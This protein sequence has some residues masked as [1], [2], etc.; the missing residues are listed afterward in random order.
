MLKP[1]ALLRPRI[2]TAAAAAAAA[3]AATTTMSASSSGGGGGG[4]GG[5]GNPWG[6]P[7]LLHIDWKRIADLPMGVEDNSGG[8]LDADTLVTGF[9]LGCPTPQPGNATGCFLAAPN[10]S[11]PHDIKCWSRPG[12]LLHPGTYHG[13]PHH[14]AWFSR[15]YAINVSAA[16]NT[17]QW[18][19][20]PLPPLSPRQ[21]TCGA[22][23]PKTNSLYIAGGWSGWTKPY[24][25]AHADAARLQRTRKG[26]WQWTTLPDLPNP[27]VFGGMTISADGHVFVFGVD[28]YTIPKKPPIPACG[29]APAALFELDP[30]KLDAG[31]ISHHFPGASGGSAFATAGNQ[32]FLMPGDPGDGKRAGVWRFDLATTSWHELPGSAVA[33]INGFANANNAIFH[34][35]Y[36]L[37]V[38]GCEIWNYKIGSTPK[39]RE[40]CVTG[41][42]GFATCGCPCH[43]SSSGNET[44]VTNVSAI[45]PGTC[46]VPVNDSSLPMTYGN[47][48]FVYD[49]QTEVLHSSHP[50]TSVYRVCKFLKWQ[51]FTVRF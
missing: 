4:A 14:G 33:Q 26:E 19:E 18:Q 28:R 34:E 3:A 40:K 2:V 36:M 45:E 47:G 48:L 22:A 5:S 17:Q 46:G 32:L 10:C 25:C 8:F 6:L 21:G 15:T 35:R 11:D 23:D 1:L 30:Q 16:P 12:A 43:A 31:W 27:V 29:K 50:V 51:G 49:T 44:V 24:P 39:G 20:L 37:L 13:D 41:G 9:G 42:S 7:E 38:G